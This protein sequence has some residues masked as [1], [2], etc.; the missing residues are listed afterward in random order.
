MTTSSPSSWQTQ[1]ELRLSE[2]A[3]GGEVI[4]YAELAREAEIPAPHR[5]HKL[6]CFLE[7]LMERDAR[8]GAPLRS[9]V[10]VSRTTGV[11]GNGFFD[12]LDELGLVFPDEDRHQV[13]IRL[14]DALT[15][16]RP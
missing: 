16:P 11:P 14:L 1:V 10:V 13:H 9:A 2:L 6:T 8:L 5:I 15:P 12:K 3:T 7:T 4:T